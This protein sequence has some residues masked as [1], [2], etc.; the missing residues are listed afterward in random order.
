MDLHTE[1]PPIV[2]LLDQAPLFGGVKVVL[3]Q[4]NMLVEAGYDVAIRCTG[5]KPDWMQV[6]CRWEVLADL[7]GPGPS[8][9]PDNAVIIGTYWTTL[10]PALRLALPGRA[11]HYCQ[12]YEA[13]Y[14]HNVAEHPAIREAYSLPLP[15]LSVSQHLV[16]LIGDQFG[17]AAQVVLQPLPPGFTA[18][19]EHLAPPPAGGRLAKVLVMSPLEIDWKGVSTALEALSEYRGRGGHFELVRLSQFEL[20]NEERKFG[21]GGEFHHHLRPEQVPDLLRGCD[22]LLAP[23]WEA[24]GFGLPV[25]EA[26]ACGVPVVASDIRCFRGWTQGAVRLVEPRFVQGWCAAIEE[27]LGEASV[28][29][30]LREQG[31]RVAE[32]YSTASSLASIEAAISCLV[33]QPR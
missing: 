1:R 6:D 15:A 8:P 22:L 25:L 27:L 30:D 12:G 7:G 16:D 26:M 11:L 19:P 3:D 20:S 33:R 14:S 31:L 29:Q 18:R 21:V 24:E 2:Y 4:A 23:S 10:A 13:S 32:G 28:W 17:R 9:V 5:E